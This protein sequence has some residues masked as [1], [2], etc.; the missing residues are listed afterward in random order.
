MNN[1]PLPDKRHLDA[2]QGWLGLGCQQEANDELEMISPQLR[3]HPDVLRVRYEVY[4]AAG[5]WEHATE[6]ANGLTMLVP[7][8]AFGVVHLAYALHALKRTKEA[9]DV[10]LPVVDKF[11]N[12]YLLRYNLACY[13]AQLGDLSASR[14][15]L[16]KAI[17]LAGASEVKEMALDDPDLEPLWEKIGEI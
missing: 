1:L 11:P 9:W 5:K 17:D 15:W 16:E 4:A 14:A 13:A 8:H 6:V 10:L 12:E 2:A 3:A 7:E